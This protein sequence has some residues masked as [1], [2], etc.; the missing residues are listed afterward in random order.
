VDVC[1]ENERIQ[2]QVEI[3]ETGR[4]DTPPA[5]VSTGGQDRSRDGF[6]AWYAGSDDE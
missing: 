5:T 2:R 6:Y 1:L 3:V 4:P